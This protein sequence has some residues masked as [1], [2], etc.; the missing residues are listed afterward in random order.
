MVNRCLRLDNET[1]NAI[2]DICKRERLNFSGFCRL[3]IH[4]QLKKDTETEDRIDTSLAHIGG[5]LKSISMMLEKLAFSFFTCVAEPEDLYEA[6]ELAAERQEK[7]MTAVTQE[8]KKSTNGNGK[9]K[10]QE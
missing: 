6:R 9:R 8:L 10:G 5:D 3:A 1:I 4:S 7:Y 2:Q